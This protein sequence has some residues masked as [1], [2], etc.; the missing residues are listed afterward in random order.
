M[1]IA[2]AALEL[3][4]ILTPLKLVGHAA[5]GGVLPSSESLEGTV[6]H[7]HRRDLIERVMEID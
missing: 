1:Q 2:H 7:Q 3:G 5:A 4:L 6:M